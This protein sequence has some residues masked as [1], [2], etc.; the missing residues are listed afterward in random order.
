MRWTATD[1]ADKTCNS[2]HS[3]GT[4]SRVFPEGVGEQSHSDK[5][6]WQHLP[7]SA[8]SSVRLCWWHL[9]FILVCCFLQAVCWTLLSSARSSSLKGRLN[10]GVPYCACESAQWIDVCLGLPHGVWKL[11][12]DSLCKE[13]H[14]GV[15]CVWCLLLFDPSTPHS[16]N[17]SRCLCGSSADITMGLTDSTTW[18]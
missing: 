7:S 16:M 11:S 17:W 8:F 3:L 10:W 4:V 14:C 9:V 2:S 6:L 1:K 13:W 5:G 18:E 12:I 15:C